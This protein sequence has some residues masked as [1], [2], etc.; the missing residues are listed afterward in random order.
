MHCSD[1]APH[2]FSSIGA[3]RLK[4]FMCSVANEGGKK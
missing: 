1:A 3:A 2:I 4:S